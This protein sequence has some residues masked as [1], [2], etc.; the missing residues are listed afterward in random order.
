M[1]GTGERGHHRQDQHLLINSTVCPSSTGQALP[2]Q[3]APMRPPL[4]QCA[5]FRAV[6]PPAPRA[7]CSHLWSAL[8]TLRTGTRFSLSLLLGWHC[9]GHLSPTEDVSD[10]WQQ[11]G[12]GPYVLH[13]AAMSLPAAPSKE[14]A[15][16][17]ASARMIKD[18]PGGA[19]TNT[20]KLGK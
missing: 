6:M 8:P 19:G 20:L 5:R 3:T 12:Q 17:N 7:H 10:P 16:P 18:R 2:S 15:S 9:G 13:A 11:G 4:T 14:L 1:K